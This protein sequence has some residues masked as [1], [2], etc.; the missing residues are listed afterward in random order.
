MGR[1][2]CSMF[3]DSGCI[4]VTGYASCD[5]KGTKGSLESTTNYLASELTDTPFGRSIIDKKLTTPNEIK[6]FQK[7][8][9]SLTYE[10]GAFISFTWGEAMGYKN[11]QI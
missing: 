10:S 4:N 8:Y 3:I 11:K 5:A 6:K 2:L 1:K 7:A 9:K